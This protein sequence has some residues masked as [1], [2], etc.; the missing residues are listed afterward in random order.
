MTETS[1]SLPLK[2][3][4]PE[5]FD[6]RMLQGA[7]LGEYRIRVEPVM[8]GNARLL[9]TLHDD[10][11]RSGRLLLQQDATLLLANRVQDNVEILPDTETVEFAWQLPESALRN[12][13]SDLDALRALTTRHQLHARVSRLCLLDEENKTLARIICGGLHYN[14]QQ[15]QW[16]E[17]Q[18]LRGYSKAFRRVVKKLT[19]IPGAVPAEYPALLQALGITVSTYRSKPA[20]DLKPDAPMKTSVTRMIAAHLTI[21]RANEAGVLADTDTEYLHDY[22]VN[23]R[24]IRS[25][26]SLVKGVYSPKQTGQL[27]TTLA[28]FMQVTNRLRDL[29]VYLLDKDDYLQK[30]P[31]ELR[32]GLELMFADF[33]EERAAVLD[34][35]QRQLA[36]RDY[37]NSMQRLQ[38]R[39]ASPEKMS[40][41]KKADRESK[42]YAS[43]LI[44]K[45]YRKVCDIAVN[46]HADTPDEEVHELRIQCKK[47][48]Y[49]ME[50][51]S[52]FYP[53]KSIKTLIKS[54]KVLQDNLGRFN[55]YSVQQ[56]SL[57]EY[58]G[59]VAKK[60]KT[61]RAAI[62]QLIE[63]LHGLQVAERQRVEANFIHFNSDATQN[64]F[65][66]LFAREEEE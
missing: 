12:Q 8:E 43:Q 61:E 20:L 50:F 56:E 16:I 30:I 46:I 21:A 53:K 48:R 34:K 27:K 65:Q 45:R 4:L 41:G 64:S 6:S 47:L 66:A 1:P 22:R 25:I 59:Q 51:F 10:L 42:H 40:A 14:D 26:L 13:L 31:A 15:V 39:F 11:I 52:Q 9:D 57:Q 29:D 19:A 38:K 49:L 35:V 37:R 2:L 18:E 28:G 23:L 5:N 36:A 3:I 33:A 17:A 60:E 44:W 63:V 7:F 62:K 55:D 54:L 24:K 32:P 58:L